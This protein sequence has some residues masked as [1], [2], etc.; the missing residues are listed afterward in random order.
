M[1]QHDVN[2]H[3]GPFR[4]MRVDSEFAGLLVAVGFVV[5]GLVSMPIATW[6]LL[7]AL[8]L[9]VGVALLLRWIRKDSAN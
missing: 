7:G 2:R 8:V 6:F 5:M 3:P 4:V 1:K 9:G